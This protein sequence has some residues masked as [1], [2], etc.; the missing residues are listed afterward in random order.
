[1]SMYDGLLSLLLRRVTLQASGTALRRAYGG[2]C[3]L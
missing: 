1:M 2:F 3:L